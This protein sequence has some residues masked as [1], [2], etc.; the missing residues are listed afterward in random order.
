[1]RKPSLWLKS[2]IKNP[3]NYVS[4]YKWKAGARIFVLTPA[5]GV[6]LKEKQFDS[7][8]MAYREGWRKI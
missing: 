3:K 5:S 1:M 8:E 7:W 2:G 4:S 6:T